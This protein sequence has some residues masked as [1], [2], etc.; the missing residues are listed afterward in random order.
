MCFV[1]KDEAE[2]LVELFFKR[3]IQTLNHTKSYILDIELAL[4]NGSRF[5]IGELME[6]LNPLLEKILGMD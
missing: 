4:L 5:D 2:L 3:P 1:Q 6:A